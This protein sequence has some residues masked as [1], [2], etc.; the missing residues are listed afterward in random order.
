MAR[1]YEDLFDADP[2]LGE[3]VLQ[4][5]SVYPTLDPELVVALAQENVP[6]DAPAIQTIALRDAEERQAGGLAGIAGSILGGVKGAVRGITTTFDF[7]WEELV[8]RNVRGAVLAYQDPDLNLWEALMSPESGASVGSRAATQVIHNLLPGQQGSEGRINL[9]SGFFPNSELAPEIE[10]AMA[11]G[12]PFE[13]AYRTFRRQQAAVGA[14]ISQLGLAATERVRLTHRNENVPVSL[15]RLFAIGVDNALP[16]VALTPNTRPFDLLSGAADLATQIYD[17]TISLPLRQLG[18]LRQGNTMFRAAG[19]LED[20]ARPAFLR[21]T[22]ADW[23][24]SRPG[25]NTVEWLAGT[26]DAATI[27]NALRRSAGRPLSVEAIRRLRDADT[28]ELVA[29]ELRQMLGIDLRTAPVPTSLLTRAT[30]EHVPTV[31][32]LIAR[33]LDPSLAGVGGVRGA[34]THRAEGTFLGRMFSNMPGRSISVSDLDRGMDQFDDFLN[35]AGFA[36]EDAAK[37]LNR[38]VDLTP[39][40]YTGARR[41]IADALSELQTRFIAEGLDPHAARA[42][43]Q[44]STHIDEL[45]RYATNAVGDA[46]HGTF[47]VRYTTVDGR[48]IPSPAP[49]LLSELVD[50]AIPVPDPRMIRRA[51]GRTKGTLGSIPARLTSNSDLQARVWVN[52][53][54]SYMSKLWKPLVLLR[55]A[56]P[57][58][59]IGEEQARMAA[60]GLDSMLSHPLQWFAYR[61]G[62]QGNL[63][64]LGDDISSAIEHSLAMSSMDDW[65][66]VGS[67]GS[68]NW[69]RMV[70]GVDADYVQHWLRDLN[71]FW[72]DPVARAIAG[73][74]AGHYVKDVDEVFETLDDVVDWL[75]DGA[76]RVHTD[77]WLTSLTDDRLRAAVSPRTVT[78]GGVTSTTTE[79]SREAVY[80]WVESIHAQI[81]RVTGGSYRKF[82]PSPDGS[83]RGT[84][85]D[86]I[87]Q[88]SPA[89]GVRSSRERWE[90][91]RPG[92]RHL[93]ESI[94]T[95][96]FG[97]LNVSH[98]LSRRTY[99]TAL[100]ELKKYE[101]LGPPGV[102]GAIDPD[103][104]QWDTLV[105]RMMS[106][107]MGHRTDNLSRSPAFRQFYWRRIAE[108][109]PYMDGATARAAA[110]AAAEAGFGRTRFRDLARKALAGHED[111]DVQSALR[112]LAAATDQSVDDLLGSRVIPGLDRTLTLEDASD[113]AKAFALEQ[114]K[115]LLY[116]IAKRRDITDI[117]RNIFPFAEAWAEI[118]GVWSRIMYQN[119]Q[120]LR[121]F[122][123]GVTSARQEGWFYEDENGEEVFAYPGGGLLGSALFGEGVTLNI[124]GRVQ[125]LNLALGSYLPGFGPIVQVPA[126]AI[127]PDMPQYETVRE[128]VMPFGPPTIESAGDLAELALPSYALKLLSAVGL[129]DPEMERLFANT[130]IDVQRA[131]ILNGEIDTTDPE[132]IRRGVSQANRNARL[133]YLMRG[134]L[135]FGA[136][137]APSF[138]L[139]AQD[140]DGEWFAFQTLTSE[141]RRLL[142]EHGFDDG[143]A[144][145]AFVARFGFD[146]TP[147]GTAK[148]VSLRPRSVTDAGLDFQRTN[149]DLFERYPLTAYYLMPD[150][151]ADEF[152]YDAYLTQLRTGDRVPVS[153][154]DWILARNDLLGRIA[155]DSARSQLGSAARTELGRARLRSLRTALIEEYPGYQQTIVGLPQRAERQE[156]IAELNRWLGDPDPRLA[157]TGAG[158]AIALY[159]NARN[160]A[161]AAV[162]RFGITEA[163][164]GAAQRSEPYRRRLEQFGEYLAG[165][166]PDFA[167]VW[168]SVLRP[169]IVDDE[170]SPVPLT[171]LGVDLGS[172]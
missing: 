156:R 55:G 81:A 20:T 8:A 7:L 31:A 72:S 56:W 98:R 75:I 126:A 54:D 69:R 61:I 21:R 94:A 143:A 68:Q 169:E 118:I 51:V 100:D 166:F 132:S 148:S 106:A 83:G 46:E 160:Q 22:A 154:E 73:V 107:L 120:V 16:T 49:Q 150:D 52:L 32:E 25:R 87:G 142:D 165:Q 151:P 67:R 11:A 101:H 65:L 164:F 90:V 110:E 123:Q 35:S 39:G 18:A 9:G 97:D 138:Q 33:R 136:P 34:L 15:G 108:Q 155:Y 115:D 105:S 140:L 23:L 47:L 44:M 38:W 162:G 64:V 117:T 144:I 149:P 88:E 121:R 13:Q 124:T 17:P 128:L 79:L 74:D 58:R 27:R 102:K 93:V 12:V 103:R 63:D 86:D 36:F 5:S 116:D 43:T 66:G 122:E 172:Q 157:T 130:A 14:P 57:V 114:T 60:D 30:G 135:Q 134:M 48:N 109:M 77:E 37:Y 99:Q 41:V 62:R 28:P 85:V 29:R 170:T 127:I 137:A 84:W 153:P 152:S 95:G 159:M 139:E 145:Q 76:G 3:R 133:L 163:G 129:R 171:L 168:S 161:I 24:A 146:P 45:R 141:Y 158:Q 147:F 104:S 42:A 59:V 167:A 80:E 1:R 70:K 92:D 119:P 40:D 53:M 4:L 50:Q 26:N 111:G 131:M 112:Q 10:Q 78:A 82:V 6:V 19:L 96:R 113:V 125:S 89:A 91:V 2:V 71:Q